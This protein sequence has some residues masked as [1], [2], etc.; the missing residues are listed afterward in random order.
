[1]EVFKRDVV[2]LLRKEIADSDGLSAKEIGNLLELPDQTDHGDIAFPCFALAK[3]R[4][5]APPKI[6]ADIAKKLGAV[7]SANIERVAA[8]GGYVNF[9]VKPER[10]AKEVLTAIY[11]DADQ[12]GAVD[13]GHGRTVV[14]EFSSPNI[15]K[16]FGIWPFAFNQYRRRPFTDLR[17]S[18]PQSSAH[19]PPWRL[20]HP[21]WQDNHRLQALGVKLILLKA[22]PS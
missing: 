19:Q 22:T 2:Q 7:E 18:S 9:F 8:V 20:G 10:L 14:I 16:P 17:L 15:A 21:I 3:K 1:M 12:Y 5:K 11:N 13:V 4:K 6:A